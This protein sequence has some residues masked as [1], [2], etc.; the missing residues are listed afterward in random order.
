MDKDDISSIGIKALK[1]N[2][3][4]VLQQV[5]RGV[6]VLETDREKVVAEIREP[7]VSY[8]ASS[9]NV[10]IREWKA[11]GVLIPASR[12]GPFLSGPPIVSLPEGTATKLLL[13]SREE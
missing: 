3:S 11:Q 1:N 2:L 4:A 8:E 12:G 10:V 9:E 13:E 6:R 5:R 7:Q